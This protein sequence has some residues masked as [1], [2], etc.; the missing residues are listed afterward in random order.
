MNIIIG[1]FFLIVSTISIASTCTTQQTLSNGV[2]LIGYLPLEP[3]QVKPNNLNLYGETVNAKPTG[4]YL[5][6]LNDK[7]EEGL[8][9]VIILKEGNKEL[10]TL[11]S[12]PL[13]RISKEYGGFNTLDNIHVAWQEAVN[14]WPEIVLTQ[15]STPVKEDRDFSP[16]PPQDF[17]LKYNADTQCY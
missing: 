6:L 17:K 12:I 1:F 10:R 15:T 8:N 2:I 9:L 13:H 16:G 3:E 14:S 11:G 7:A 5:E 4:K